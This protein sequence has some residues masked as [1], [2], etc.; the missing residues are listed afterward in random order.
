MSEEKEVKQKVV[1]PHWTELQKFDDTI[2]NVQPYRCQSTK[3]WIVRRLKGYGELVLR[4]EFK[5]RE[6]ALIYFEQLKKGENE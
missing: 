6:D 2:I 5:E 4:K 3:L 1:A